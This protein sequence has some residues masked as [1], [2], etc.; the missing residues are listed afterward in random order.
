MRPA[1]GV[2]RRFMRGRPHQ[3]GNVAPFPADTGLE[4]FFAWM[5]NNFDPTVSW[6]D[7]EFIRSE[8]T[9]PLIIKG[10]LDPADAIEAVPGS[11]RTASWF[12]TM[13]V[14]SW[15]GC[16]RPH[17]RCRPIVDAVADRLTILADGGVRSGLDVVRS[18][19]ARRQGRP[20]RARLG[21]CSGRRRREG[22]SRT[23]FN[24]S[25]RKCASPWR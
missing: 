20:A 23:C 14:A 1:L 9:G 24:S 19:R 2:G 17:V 25:K 11:A 22:G 3:L 4:D 12:P 6:Q 16:R 13:A 8:W 18:A 5:R 10:I 7:L 15:T 21:L